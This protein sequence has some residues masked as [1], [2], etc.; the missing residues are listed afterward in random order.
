MAIPSGEVRPSSQSDRGA[1][2]IAVGGDSGRDLREKTFLPQEGGG[3]VDGRLDEFAAAMQK[4][5]FLKRE[6]IEA[7]QV[8]RIKQSGSRTPRI[9][10]ERAN[11]QRLT[12]EP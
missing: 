1:G 5:M 11:A 8:A 12:T 2:R 3:I 6:D 4:P 10:I 7:G 9:D